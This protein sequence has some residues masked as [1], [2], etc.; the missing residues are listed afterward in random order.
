LETKRILIIDDD[1]LVL[2]TIGRVL[3]LEGFEVD[4]AET[5][6][7]AIEKSNLHSYNLALVD[8]RLPD[9]EGTKLLPL[10]RDPHPRMVKIMLTGY[11]SAERKNDA[12]KNNADDYILKPVS[13]PELLKTI[14]KHLWRQ[15]EH[16]KLKSPGAIES[17]HDVLAVV[18][19]GAS[20]GGPKA[21]E[22]VLSKIPD[23]LPAGFVVSQHMPNGFTKVLAQRLDAMSNVRVREAE[24]EDVLQ[25]SDVL[26]TPGGFNMEVVTGGKVHLQ[27]A[28]QTPSPSI[29]VMMNSAADAYGSKTI[30]ILLTGML[31]DGV[32]GMKAIKNH[33]GITI[34]QDE[35]SSAVYG[36]P[37]AAL[38]AGAADYSVNISDIPR[39]ITHVLSKIIDG[40]RDN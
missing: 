4:R 21:L 22:R 27:K 10:L 19:I 26:I 14:N 18:A 37:K 12:F 15:E 40:K 29:D 7:E 34:V 33:G 28:E 39:Q 25:P 11:P 35:V 3:E 6:K 2:S 5:G 9:I 16:F 24:S 8:F 1:L 13:V 20:A 23:H 17:V 38:E 30:G 31:T 32:L 36:M